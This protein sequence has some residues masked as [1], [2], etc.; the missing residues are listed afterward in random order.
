[1]RSSG[2]PWNPAPLSEPRTP[3]TIPMP[4]AWI[5]R[6]DKRNCMSRLTVEPLA[7]STTHNKPVVA[8]GSA[9]SVSAASP[10]RNGFGS[11]PSAR[12]K[13]A[14]MAARCGPGA[15]R[16]D[17]GSARAVGAVRRSSAPSRTRSRTPGPPERH[18]PASTKWSSNAVLPIPASPTTTS[19]RLQRSRTAA[20][21]ASSSARSA[22]RSRSNTTR[23]YFSESPSQ[24]GLRSSEHTSAAARSRPLR[25]GDRSADMAREPGSARRME[26]SHRVRRC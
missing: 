8:A 1:M 9:K 15:R 2:K 6:R 22:S 17:Q 4:S 5:R 7:S 18:P 21:T 23:R 3:N 14:Q 10:T 16:S 13:A 20:S 26:A 25:A 19:A 24:H 12:P 11:S